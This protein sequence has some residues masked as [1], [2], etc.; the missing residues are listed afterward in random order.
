MKAFVS[1]Q[2]H[3]DMKHNIVLIVL[4]ALII[5]SCEKEEAENKIP[6]CFLTSLQNVSSVTIGDTLLIEIDAHDRDGLV[7]KIDLI[8]NT[9]TV[10]VFTAEPYEYEWITTDFSAGQYVV[11]ATATDDKLGTF[12]DEKTI[13]ILQTQVPVADFSV[14]E[15]MI[16]EG[17]EVHFTNLSTNTP[18][19]YVWAFGDGNTSALK[20]PVHVYETHGIFTVTLTA[21][22]NAGSD[23]K[24]K[25]ELIT[26]S[27][28]INWNY[29]CP[30]TPTVTDV[31]GN[32]YNTV[33]IGEQCWMK[34]NLRTTKFPDNRNITDGTTLGEIPE[35]RTEKY[36]F[37]YDNNENLIETY[38]YLYNWYAI[39]NTEDSNYNADNSLQV[40]G[41]CPEGWHVPNSS[42]FGDLTMFIRD[43]SD[44]YIYPSFNNWGL[45]NWKEEG[46]VHW[47]EGNDGKNESGFTALPGGHRDIYGNYQY[48]GNKAYFW[49]ASNL[50]NRNYGFVYDLLL[51]EQSEYNFGKNS[52]KNEGNS[53]RCIKD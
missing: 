17:E 2:K 33:Q 49:G 8:I 15:V 10:K 25:N 45:Y 41:I 48:L 13:T 7:R 3:E 28:A 1:V 36:Y 9:D 39:M 47:D 24:T 51:K 6:T 44:L 40:Q 22:N 43:H 34:E 19:T 20:N 26:V 32:V 53:L 30:G 11:K 35:S 38:G 5:F 46:T 23:T 16:I 50:T 42:D 14:D 21:T 12:T 4:F 29:P 52:R 18:T 31:E 27:Q 37:L